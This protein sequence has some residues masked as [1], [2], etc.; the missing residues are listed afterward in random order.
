MQQHP[1]FERIGCVWDSI[2]YSCAYDACLVPLYH[3]YRDACSKNA[4][5]EPL[6]SFDDSG[7]TPHV[8]V[9][10][11]CRTIFSNAHAVADNISLGTRWRD[12]IRSL[13]WAT[14]PSAFPR[15]LNLSNVNDVWLA[16]TN[17]ARPLCVVERYCSACGS[18]P[19]AVATLDLPFTMDSSRVDAYSEF[20]GLQQHSVSTF[21]TWLAATLT[22]AWSMSASPSPECPHCNLHNTSNLRARIVG[23]EP[24][25]LPF[26]TSDYVVYPSHQLHFWNVQDASS[27]TYKLTALAHAGSAHFTSRFLDDA[28]NVWYHDGLENGGSLVLEMSAGS[29]V[30]DDLALAKGRRLCSVV[31]SRAPK[32]QVSPIWG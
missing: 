30:P 31:Y 2:E 21:D 28:G 6:S 23:G 7:S 4:S 13:L 5:V 15:G 29:F 25:L 19:I 11:H 14:N 16:V 20:T 24:D 17:H 26:D 12:P 27:I 10:L 1:L 32:Y 9:S 18:E 22:S 3:W 8:D